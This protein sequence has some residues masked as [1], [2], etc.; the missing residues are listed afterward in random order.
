MK[1]QNQWMHS[2]READTNFARRILKTDSDYRDNEVQ[3]AA[4]N[5]LLQ[6]NTEM[7][8]RQTDV[9]QI[10]KIYIQPILFQ[11]LFLFKFPEVT[12]IR[13]FAK[14]HSFHLRSSVVKLTLVFTPILQENLIYPGVGCFWNTD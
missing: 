8:S 4:K 12:F 10:W 5:F 3:S 14:S 6:R 1:S 11:T 7:E 9:M 13:S 2:F